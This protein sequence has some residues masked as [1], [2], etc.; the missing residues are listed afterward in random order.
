MIHLH[1]NELTNSDLKGFRIGHFDLLALA[2]ASHPL[3]GHFHAVDQSSDDSVSID[4]Q[5]RPRPNEQRSPAAAHDGT[6][7]WDLPSIR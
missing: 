1:Q 7:G 2:R 6:G 4:T 3:I 5:R